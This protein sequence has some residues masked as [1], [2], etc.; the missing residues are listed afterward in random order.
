[1]ATTNVKVIV[2]CRPLSEREK[3]RGCN[4]I[5]TVNEST[6]QITIGSGANGVGEPIPFTFDYTCV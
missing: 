4:E 2:R 1:M 6:H 3:N 5:V